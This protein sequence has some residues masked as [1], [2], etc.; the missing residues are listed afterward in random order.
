MTVGVSPN[1]GYL[2][3]T[4]TVVLTPLNPGFNT[5]NVIIN[6]GD[7]VA[8]AAISTTTGVTGTINLFAGA[9]LGVSGDWNRVG[10]NFNNTVAHEFGHL[11]N[12][13]DRYLDGVLF[14]GTSGGISPSTPMQRVVNSS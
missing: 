11:Y 5:V 14:L 7:G 9:N 10:Q 6:Q 13:T 12:L 3:L 1:C 8:N 2:D 4:N